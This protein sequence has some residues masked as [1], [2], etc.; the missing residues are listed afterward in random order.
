[1]SKAKNKT[2]ATKLSF[3]DYINSITPEQ[4]KKDCI[5]IANLMKLVTQQDPVM[6]GKS[7]VG[8]GSKHLKY[9]SGRELDWFI[10]GFSARK[11]AISLYLSFNIQE[12]DLSKLGKYKTGKGCLY[13]KKLSDINVTEL[14]IIFESVVK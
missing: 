10:M 4:K 1:M 3:N 12:H 9:P 2:V 7:I 11:D 13:I 6:W 8:F 5:E 14:K